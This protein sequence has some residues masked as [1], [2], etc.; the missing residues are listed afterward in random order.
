MKLKFIYLSMV[1]AAGLAGTASCS[2]DDDNDN[3]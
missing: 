1:L 3:L 2:S